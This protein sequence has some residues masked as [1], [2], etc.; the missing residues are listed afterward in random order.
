MYPED[1]HVAHPRLY[2]AP[3]FARPPSLAKGAELPPDPDDLPIAVYQTDEER[4]L[5]ERLLASPFGLAEQKAPEPEPQSQPRPFLLGSLA[6]KI[7]R[8]AS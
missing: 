3:A 7:L 4:D 6:G 2:G 5:A 1:E 8:R